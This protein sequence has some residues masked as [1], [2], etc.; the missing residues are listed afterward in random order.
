MAIKKGN[1]GVV[2]VGGVAVA[3]VTA[4]SYDEAVGIVQKPVAMGDV[5]A[6]YISDGVKTGTGSIEVTYDPA[7]VPQAALLSG[8][9]IVLV[10]HESGTAVGGVHHTGTVVI[11]SVGMAGGASD[12]LKRSISF[13][14]VLIE[15]VN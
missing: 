10:V 1:D 13:S 6:E 2:M 9:S 15:G 3:E 4:W 11:G 12:L 5:E 7:D 14:G 8:A